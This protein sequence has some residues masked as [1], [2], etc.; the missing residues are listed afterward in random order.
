MGTSLLNAARAKTIMAH[1]LSINVTITYDWTVHGA[2]TDR[3]LLQEIA[4]AEVDGV[5]NCD[6]FFMV[7]PGRFGTHCELGLAYAFGKPIVILDENEAW[8]T[9]F[10][11][12]PNIFRFSKEDSA[13]DC[14]LNLLGR[15]Q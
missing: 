1:L 12:L 13:I 9:S 11:H 6:V 7:Q 4:L 15:G 5:K 2:V 14:L 8:N 3:N 10:Y